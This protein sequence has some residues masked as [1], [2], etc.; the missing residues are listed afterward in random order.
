M[1][2]PSPGSQRES[3]EKE[4][5]SR[6]GAWVQTTQGII[7]IIAGIVAVLGATGIAFAAHYSQ[8]LVSPAPTLSIPAATSSPSPSALVTTSSASAPEPSAPESSV[9]VTSLSSTEQQLANMLN[10]SVLDYCTSHSSLEGGAVI[11]A[12][13]CDYLN[14][15]PTRRPLVEA[16]ASGTTAAWFRDN[17][18]GF[19]NGN[20]CADGRYLGVYD[21]NGSV[22]GQLGCTVESNG[23][24]RIVWVVGNQVGVIAEGSDFQALYSWWESYSCL[25]PT[26][27]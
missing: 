10:S 9:P 18:A 26:A 25:V 16:L 2:G 1:A 7:S 24:L 15:G 13:N 3:P 22:A 17:T 8:P 11:A 12:V 19:V 5:R 20:D 6:I 23:L 27:C 21:H 4:S 14:S